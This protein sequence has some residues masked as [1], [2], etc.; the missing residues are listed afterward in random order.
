MGVAEKENVNITYFKTLGAK[1][2]C[3]IYIDDKGKSH[4][5]TTVSG[6]VK[7]YGSHELLRRFAEQDRT[8]NPL[9]LFDES[10]VFIKAGGNEIVYNDTSC[11]VKIDG[12]ELY[13]PTNAVIRP[14]TY[15]IGLSDDYLKLLDK[16]GSIN[17]I[18]LIY[19]DYYDLNID[20]DIL[21]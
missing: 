13:V 10:F 7:K 6:V 19:R 12:I 4:M 21:L 11:F 5:N 8:N 2:Y 20:N 17:F 16:Y 3:Y 18:T 9:D 1:K 14:S 15:E